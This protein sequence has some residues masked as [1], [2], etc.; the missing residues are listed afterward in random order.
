MVAAI[1]KKKFSTFF[2]YQLWKVVV[3]V[4]N[5]KMS[6][7]AQKIGQTFRDSI[8]KNQ[9]FI[10]NGSGVINF[11]MKPCNPAFLRERWHRSKTM[12]EMLKKDVLN[13][14]FNVEFKFGIK[15]GPFYL[16]TQRWRRFQVFPKVSPFWKYFIWT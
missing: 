5:K 6:L 14:K 15:M 8:K 13:S 9:L 7:M 16:K 12:T 10:S 4:W 11:L 2:Y 3:G 1:K